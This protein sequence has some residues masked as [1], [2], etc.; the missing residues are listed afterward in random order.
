M[1]DIGQ[2]LSSLGLERYAAVFEREELTLAN[3]RDL[4]E[5]S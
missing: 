5:A 3:L 2:W 4:T 1:S